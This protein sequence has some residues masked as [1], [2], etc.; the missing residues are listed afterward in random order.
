MGGG[1]WD[2]SSP[3]PAAERMRLDPSGHRRD[4]DPPLYS[5]AMVGSRLE[6]IARI[7]VPLATFLVFLPSL[8]FPFL[9]DD[10]S[11]VVDSRVI[12]GPIGEAFRH[13]LWATTPSTDDAASGYY[14]PLLLV[15]LF[16]DRLLFGLAPW[17]H[18]L[19]SVLWHCLAVMLAGSLF[20]GRYRSAGFVGAA[21]VALHPVQVESVAFVSARNDLMAATF[22]LGALLAFERGRWVVGGV[23]TLCGL[24]SK[25]LV[26]VAPA[27]VLV[28]LAGRVER[29]RV[30][31]SIVACTGAL[32]AGLALRAWAGVSFGPPPTSGVALEGAAHLVAKVFW[33]VGLTSALHLGWA[34]STPWW[35]LAVAAIG[36]LVAIRFGVFRP[37]V[38]F[39]VALAPALVGVA[40]AGLVS[41]RY[42]YVPMVG[43]GWLVAALL[44]RA[45]ERT[46]T[47]SGLALLLAGAVGSSLQLRMWRSTDA[48]WSETIART[49]NAYAYGSYAKQLELEGRL[50]E[51]ADFYARATQPPQPL[52]HSCFNIVEIHM[53]R[54][55]L[56][57]AVREG[58]RALAAGCER[59]PEILGPLSLA[60]A[61]SAKWDEAER[62]ASELRA[63]PGGDPTTK[64]EVAALAA[65]AH[66]GDFAPI[67]SEIAAKPHLRASIVDSVAIVL[68][69]GGDPA[70]ADTVNALRT[71]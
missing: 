42:L 24:L 69:A 34:T 44:A 63:R 54:A 25:E 22:V 5:P 21:V 65:A 40:R 61:M 29:R 56:P 68:V 39:A 15:D 46:V 45:S 43:V 8:G 59:S 64:S 19:H 38:F 57:S 20:S 33:P 50:D 14:R 62:L 53:K 49:P 11:L 35:S 58:E 48:L 37:I 9:W 16:I 2:P 18:H 10:Q 55:D 13:D 41:D 12:A 67:L 17:G 36:S 3:S 47:A 51:A 6:R 7:L 1:W 66:R 28:W 31:A 60:Y 70:H 71:P 4:P 32:G 27:L 23:L 30:I 26:L 52:P